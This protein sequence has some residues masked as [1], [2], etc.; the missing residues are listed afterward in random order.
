MSGFI[1]RKQSLLILCTGLCAAAASVLLLNYALAGPRLGPVY[2]LLLNCRSTPPVSGEILLI[3]TDEIVEP[4]EIS[5]VLITLSEMDAS[6]LVIEVPVLGSSMGRMES[7][8]EIRWRFYDEYV[9]LGKNIRNLFEA[10]R[11]GS[12]PPSES[13]AYVE[14][15]VELAERGRDRLVAALVRQDDDGTVPAAF[16]VF[17]RALEAADIRPQAAKNIPWYSWVKADRDGKVRR[18]APLVARGREPPGALE[19]QDTLFVEETAPLVEHI[20]Y[21]SLKSRWEE[22]GLEYTEQGPFLVN[23]KNSA[24]TF[25]FPLDRNGNILIEK[26]EKNKSFRRLPL[27]IFQRYDEAGR[28]MRRLLKD[29]ESL[30]VYSQTRPERIPLILYDYASSLKEELLDE[31]LPE[32]LDAWRK[33]RAEYIAS[34]DVFLYGPAEM[35]LVNGYEELIATE[36][37]GEEGIAKLENLRD[38]LIRAFVAMRETHLELTEL[39]STLG[40][41]LAGSFCIM[42]P[43]AV[44][45]GNGLVE[46]SALLANTL[47]TGQGI[48][49]GQFG[50]VVFWSLLVVCIMLVCIHALR[51]PVVLAAGCAASLLCAAGFGWSFIVSACW[52]DPL[53]PALS[54]ATGTLVIFTL[55]LLIIRRGVR[56]FRWAYG[57]AVGKS[58]LARLVKAGR[59]S[60]SETICVRAAIIAIKNPYLIRCEDTE[61]PVQ[62][63]KSA[64]AFRA[65]VSGAFKQAGAVVLAYEGDTVLACFGSPPELVCREPAKKKSWQGGDNKAAARA[66]GCVRELLRAA[67]PDTAAP[68]EKP[69]FAAWYFGIDWGDCAFSWSGETGYIANGRPV[70]RARILAALGP[71]YKAQALISEAVME[72]CGQ[73]A[74]KLGSFR[75]E[76]GGNENFYSLSP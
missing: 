49:P 12:I 25:R 54:S 42:G 65:A 50:L 68:D 39:Y 18:I 31:P 56:Q 30:G 34:L 6:G 5:L 51:P 63:A 69:P 29:A 62:A 27:D 57:P 76:G 15:L 41:T 44:S 70:A 58:C 7:N 52:I 24:E 46:T 74:Q 36:A 22:S 19:L 48:R 20:V 38:E 66:A 16:R 40:K 10:I 32:K 14:N 33:A 47:L 53:I 35:Y 17:G 21:R 37:L 75:Q 26:P 4:A 43:A 28:L 72:A 60:L 73:P 11:V 64:A 71:R 9:L 55:R 61:E 67:Q 3:D 23:R 13:P 8:E 59:P 2:D 1:S 45:G